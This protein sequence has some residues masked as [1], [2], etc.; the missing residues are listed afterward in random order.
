MA[1]LILLNKPYGV[2]T[3][4]TDREN[5]R[6]TLADYVNL[7]GVYA[8]GRLDRDSEGLLLLTD[9]GPLNAQIAHPKYKKTKTYWVQVD[10]EPDD[11]A[12]NALRN[13]VMLKDGMTLPANVRRMDEPAGLWE[14]DPPVRFRKLIPTSWLELTISEGRNRQVRR[15]TAAVGFPTL[16]LVRYAIG[17]WTLDG[18][19]PGQWRE[20]EV[21]APKGQA[22]SAGSSARPASRSSSRPSSRPVS[23]SGDGA[24]VREE[25]GR[26]AKK[27][28]FSNREGGQGLAK[29]AKRPDAKPTGAAR[30]GPKNVSTDSSSGSTGRPFNRRRPVK[31]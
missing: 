7:P 12:L 22:S 11:A 4:F 21:A 8:A 27:P 20:I 16:R 13:G 23:R 25:R 24:D 10:G 28:P 3:Q 1:R 15:M 29:G 17:D 5:G 30:R 26:T 18:L 2:L 6:R 19:A 9:N 31:D 14:R